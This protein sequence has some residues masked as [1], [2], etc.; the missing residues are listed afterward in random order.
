MAYNVT[1][2]AARV[3]AD[4][5]RPAVIERLNTEHGIKI[6]VGTLASYEKKATQPD[7]ITAKALAAIYNIPVDN[8]I[9]L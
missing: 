7:D 2:K 9:F 8:I 1:L 3:N 5:T 4:L 6:T